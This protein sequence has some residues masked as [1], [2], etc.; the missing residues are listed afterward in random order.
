VKHASK[1]FL[2][3][4]IVLLVLGVPSMVV[5]WL[6]VDVPEPTTWLLIIGLPVAAFGVALI[7]VAMV[8]RILRDARS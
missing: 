2:I 7:G 6:T 4:G 3:A 1:R 8:L 5:G